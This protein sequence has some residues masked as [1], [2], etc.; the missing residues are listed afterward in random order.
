MKKILLLS[1]ISCM[2]SHAMS[3]NETEELYKEC[4]TWLQDMQVRTIISYI[5]RFKK[6][7]RLQHSGATIEVG[8]AVSKAI[9]DFQEEVV[10]IHR[11]IFPNI[12]DQ[13]PVMKIT[14]EKMLQVNA[15]F[16]SKNKK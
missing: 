15:L 5:T 1:L 11:I 12:P 8:A 10:G 14:F 2:N 6:G 9:L 4:Q 3:P 16:E 13:N 7:S